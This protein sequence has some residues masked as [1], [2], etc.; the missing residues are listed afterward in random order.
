MI[1]N[2]EVLFSF[3]FLYLTTGRVLLLLVRMQQILKRSCGPEQKLFP[4]ETLDWMAA[5]EKK[6]KRAPYV[7]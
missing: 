6:K 2:A 7:F 5:L 1:A 3:H 4:S